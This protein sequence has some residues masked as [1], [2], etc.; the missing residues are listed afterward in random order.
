MQ[1]IVPLLIA[2]VAVVASISVLARKGKLHIPGYVGIAFVAF[3]L[4]LA[5]GE[6]CGIKGIRGSG[7]GVVLSLS[8]YLCI[9]ATVGS[10]VALLFYRCPP[11]E[12]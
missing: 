9:S 8:C 5:F 2:C 3:A 6:L 10:I 4:A 11:G 7:L 12:I 1:I